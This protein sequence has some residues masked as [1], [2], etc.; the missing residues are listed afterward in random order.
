MKP[1][2]IT[3][4]GVI[5]IAIAAGVAVFLVA[6]GGGGSDASDTATQ[7]AERAH[8]LGLLD[9]LPVSWVPGSV[10]LSVGLGVRQD[11]PIT[12]TTRVA[13]KNAK[14]VFVPDLRNVVTVAP[15]TIPVLAAG[16][17]ATVTLTFAPAATDTRKVIAGIVLL[18]DKSGTISK[19][20]PVKVSLVKPA[21]WQVATSGQLSGITVPYPPNLTASVDPA[22]GTIVLRPLATASQ[23]TNPD[24]APSIYIYTDQ[25]PSNQTTSEYY[26]D[27][28]GG[29]ITAVTVGGR[30]GYRFTPSATLS[31]TVVVVVPLAGKFLRIEDSSD[32][33]QDNG[34]FD[35][36]LKTIVIGG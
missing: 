36:I 7:E 21:D 17:T 2:H 34:V 19:P 27:T 10:E 29:S 30:T 11:V 33:F 4:K 14:I 31:S 28:L 5:G 26:N 13:L 1:I 6:C 3:K 12:L 35:Q 15:D 23:S 24:G 8:A 9:K 32:H 16:Q 18:F 22:D 20:L 25:N